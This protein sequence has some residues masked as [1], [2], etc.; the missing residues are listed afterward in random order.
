MPSSSSS[1][2]ALSLDEALAT[3]FITLSRHDWSH[4]VIAL[5]GSELALDNTSSSSSS[6][7]LALRVRTPTGV[8][9]ARAS[10]STTL[11][12]LTQV[13]VKA[14]SHIVTLMPA[15][16]DWRAVFDV[17]AVSR[18]VVCVVEFSIRA[19]SAAA[20]AHWQAMLLARLVNVCLNMKINNRRHK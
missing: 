20:Y 9:C 11:R 15:Q 19:T 13:V 17:D 5:R 7:S 1:S 2:S 6:S 4:D 8:E 3:L 16:S 14:T 12:R 18:N 10:T